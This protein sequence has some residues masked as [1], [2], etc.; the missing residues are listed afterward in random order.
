MK[1]VLMT[2][3]NENGNRVF[4]KDRLKNGAY[5]YEAVDAT[6][7][8]IGLKKEHVIAKV[9]DF[10]NVRVSGN[11]IYPLDEVDVAPN[12]KT[13]PALYNRVPYVLYGGCHR[14]A[15]ERDQVKRA[16]GATTLNLKQSQK[17][18]KQAFHSLDGFDY[19]GIFVVLPAVRDNNTGAMI[20]DGRVV[21]AWFGSYDAMSRLV[22]GKS[23]F[24]NYLENPN[25]NEKW[26]RENIEAYYQVFEES[27]KDV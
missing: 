8:H 1:Y 7:L 24:S 26:Y 25:M 10:V 20:E 9:N 16:L 5:Q 14:F 12:Q 2:E 21:Y 18:L 11:S 15:H 3:V 13:I 27:G 23:S 19:Y 22:K 6:G 4:K 17:E